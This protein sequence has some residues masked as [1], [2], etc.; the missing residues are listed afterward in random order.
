MSALSLAPAPTVRAVP[1]RQLAWVAWRRYRS[2]LIAI[3]AVLAVI[4]IYLVI[5]G[6]RMRSAYAGYTSCRPTESARCNL[7]WQTFRTGYGQVG[8]LGAVL[9]F[10]PGLIGTFA[11]APVFARE[12]ETGT[13]RYAWTQGV[14]R[15]RWAIAAVVP[16]AVGVALF[17]AA[18]GAVLSWHNAPLAATGIN[19]RLHATVFPVT[20]LAG[21]GWALLGFALGVLLGL[22]WRRV[23]PGLVTA[24]AAW[25]GLAFL[26]ANLRLHYL[27]P[28]TTTNLQLPDSDM[29]MSQWWTKGGVRVSAARI[30]DVLQAIGF[31]N[32]G[33]GKVTAQPNSNNSVD[34]VQYLLQHGYQQVTGYQPDHRYWTIQWIEFGWLTALAVLALTAAIWLLE[35]RSA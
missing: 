25:F 23:L 15:T 1:W 20:G 9:L 35:R 6:Q 4:A 7:A 27:T 34:P 32:T 28:L 22:L 21:A 30:N 13:Y 18:F 5:D 11:G 12:M 2:A 17:T 3:G 33:T 19:P 26:A 10:L 16:G 8:I 24:F 29:S 31:Q 14:G